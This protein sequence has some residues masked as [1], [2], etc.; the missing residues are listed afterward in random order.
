VPRVFRYSSPRARGSLIGRRNVRGKSFTFSR[1]GDLMKRF[2]GAVLVTVLVSGLSSPLRADEQGTKAILDKAIKALG[3]EEKLKKAETATWKSK[4]TI[5]FD[6]NDN[7]FTSQATVQGL[8]HYRSEFDGEFNGNPVKGVTVLNGDKG[9]RKF[10]DNSM[11][12]DDDGVANEKRTVYLQVVPVT[13]LP[14]TG[15]GFKTE[16]TGEE[17]VSGK[18]ASGLK[19]TGPDGK[20]FTLY[21]DK[22]SGLPVKLVAKVV[23]FGGDEFTQETTYDNYKDFDGIKKATKVESKRDGEKFVT[24]EVTDFKT[25]DKVPDGTFAEPQ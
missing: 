2:Q 20:E 7:A 21:F 8:D 1:R 15:K 17:K 25:M 4:G 12:M 13:I 11:E 14:L 24:V 3:G 10:G 22:E 23:G 18:P 19:V 6:N 16:T 5:S 9:W